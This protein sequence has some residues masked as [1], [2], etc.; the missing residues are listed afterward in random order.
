[1]PVLDRTYAVMLFPVMFDRS[2]SRLLLV[3]SSASCL[4]LL[5]A[6]LAHLAR[7]PPLVS[8]SS[9]FPHR[10]FIVGLKTTMENN[11]CTENGPVVRQ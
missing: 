3:P 10:E 4:P 9:E 1:M 11:A 7:S 2:T 8:M 6:P 5:S